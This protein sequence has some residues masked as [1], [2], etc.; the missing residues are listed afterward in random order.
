MEPKHVKDSYDSLVMNAKS[1]YKQNNI[2]IVLDR[3]MGQDM[4]HVK[5]NK[6]SGPQRQ[7]DSRVIYETEFDRR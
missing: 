3:H 2:Q 6:E 1:I 7:V 5:N 4:N